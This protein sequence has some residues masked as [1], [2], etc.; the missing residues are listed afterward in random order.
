[1]NND[2]EPFGHPEM[3]LPPQAPDRGVIHYRT[4]GDTTAAELHRGDDIVPLALT[5]NAVLR[6]RYAA[7]RWREFVELAA[8]IVRRESK[9]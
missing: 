3:P 9:S 8:E 5:L 6:D 2:P 1:M 4:L 7:A